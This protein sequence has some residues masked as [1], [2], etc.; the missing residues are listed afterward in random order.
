M[1][2]LHEKNK[3]LNVRAVKH[4]MKTEKEW[5]TKLDREI[6]NDANIQQVIDY[7]PTIFQYE[8]S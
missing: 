8:N 7:L 6:F 3:T 4:I 2:E 5:K 1:L